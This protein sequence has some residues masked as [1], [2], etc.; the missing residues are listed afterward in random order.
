MELWWYVQ[1][2]TVIGFGSKKEGTEGV[3]GSPLGNDDLKQ[4]KARFGF[5]PGTSEHETRSQMCEHIQ[6]CDESLGTTSSSGA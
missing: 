5:N 6:M 4:V 2:K 1:V 3:H